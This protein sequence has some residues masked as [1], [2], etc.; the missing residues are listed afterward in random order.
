VYLVHEVGENGKLR[1][2]LLGSGPEAGAAVCGVAVG[3]QIQYRWI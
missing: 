3:C 1:L 2:L